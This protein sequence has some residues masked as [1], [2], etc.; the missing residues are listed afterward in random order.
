MKTP[1]TSTLRGAAFAVAAMVFL[2]AHSVAQQTPA[3]SATSSDAA[4]RE[5][6]DQVRQL[7]TTLKAMRE[8]NTQSRAE[9]RQLR[10]DLQATHIHP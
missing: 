4:I 5:L 10:Q 1:G 2:H 7:Q 8:E 3:A 9:M 6:Q